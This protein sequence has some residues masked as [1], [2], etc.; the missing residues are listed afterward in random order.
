MGRDGL[1]AALA[2]SPDLATLARRV[3]E[4]SPARLA[5]DDRSVRRF[6]LADDNQGK[7]V[8]RAGDDCVAVKPGGEATLPHARLED[9][10]G[11]PRPVV[12]CRLCVRATTDGDFLWLVQ[13]TDVLEA[14]WLHRSL[15]A[16][17]LVERDGWEA[18]PRYR[19]ETG[20][21][22]M[23]AWRL[24]R[25]PA[26]ARNSGAPYPGKVLDDQLHE[27]AGKLETDG[28]LMRRAERTAA[29]VVAARDD[30]GSVGAAAAEVV[31]ARSGARRDD[32]ITRA[33]ET[34][35]WC[36]VADDPDQQPL[37]M[38]AEELCLVRAARWKGRVWPVPTL[39]ASAYRGHLEQL[40]APMSL[41]ES[42]ALAT[43]ANVVC[44]SGVEPSA[45]VSAA[46][47]LV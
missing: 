44:E 16:A 43:A 8:H 27:R 21:L 20:R 25:G 7:G 37:S 6:M 46:H 42:A 9:A 3:V 33:R 24:R 12:L 32:A 18:D 19:A 23:V 29:S 34:L 47:A 17:L 41:H 11:H 35:G 45:S 28:N 30:G 40:S 2:S 4:Q 22:S 26:A 36:L 38:L 15:T 39:V 13:L 31:R 1:L 5:L 14:L 10:L